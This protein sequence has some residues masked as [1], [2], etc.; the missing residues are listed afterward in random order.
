MKR[1]GFAISL[2][3]FIVLFRSCPLP[4][5][6]VAPES[7][8]ISREDMLVPASASLTE[9]PSAS[10]SLRV[11][12]KL[13]YT[14]TWGVVPAGTAI[15]EVDSLVRWDGVD[16]YWV[17]ITTRTNSFLDNIHKVR[18]SIGSLIETSLKRSQ[19]YRKKQEEGSFRRDDELV[20][21]YRREMAILNRG[22]KL[23]NT[24]KIRQD[25]DLLDPFGVLYY[26]RGMNLRVGDQ[27]N[28]R[29]T[30]GMAMYLMQINVLKR[31]RVKA[32]TGYYD[33]LKIEPKMQKLEGVFNKK[34]NAK[35]H[36]WVTNDHLKIPVKM[37][38]EIFLGSIQGLLKE[39]HG[40]EGAVR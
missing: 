25:E 29:V 33:C 2:L 36:I 37:Q 34:V 10:A 5:S 9:Q 7:P 13:V 3:F 35:L 15:L 28:A 12:E 4:A 14:L 23:K 20:I 27:I 17:K 39:V 16:C 30:D 24:M 6:G 18:D 38:S 32:W 26:V 11:G 22:G 21:D 1:I 19:Y 31:E 40:P 8:A